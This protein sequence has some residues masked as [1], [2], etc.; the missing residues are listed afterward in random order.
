MSIL[1]RISDRID[2]YLQERKE[3]ADLRRQEIERQERIRDC[4]FGMGNDFEDTVIRMFDPS[5]FELIHRT[6]RH[7]EAH[8]RYVRGM[9]LP[10]LRFREISTGRRFWIECKYRSHF[11][12]DWSIEWCSRAQLTAYKRTSHEYRGPV[13]IVIGVGGTVERPEKVYCLD[14]ARINFTTLYYGTF[15]ENRVHREMPKTLDGLL[16]VAN[17]TETH[18]RRSSEQSRQIPHRSFSVVHHG[19]EVHVSLVRFVVVVVPSDDRESRIAAVIERRFLVEVR[20]PAR[21]VQFRILTAVGQFVGDPVEIRVPHDDVGAEPPLLPL[22]EL[23][24]LLQSG[25]SE[26]H[27][28]LEI[29]AL[30]GVHYLG[31]HRII[32]LFEPHPRRE[33]A[34]G[35]NGSL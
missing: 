9:E 34:P 2:R 15:R 26:T 3:M 17:R 11:E 4:H 1:S 19:T 25:R 31:M 32:V 14:L 20:G 22:V 6:P 12:P 33:C 29:H 24:P 18:R 13:L 30:R 23:A 8:G 21:H 5:V 28:D 16:E 10:D 27:R 7:D 35:L